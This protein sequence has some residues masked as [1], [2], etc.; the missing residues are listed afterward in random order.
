MSESQSTTI[1]REN[2]QNY[3][4]YLKVYQAHCRYFGYKARVFGGWKFFIFEQDYRIW[5]NQK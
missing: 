2:F 5:K 3:R 1:L 4:E